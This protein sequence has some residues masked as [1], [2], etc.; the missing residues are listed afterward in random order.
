MKKIEPRSPSP[1]VG[2][3]LVALLAGACA[4]SEMSPSHDGAA[5]GG[6]PGAG[7]AG[8]AAP[9]AGASPA[10]KGGAGG[11]GGAGG[12]TGGTGGMKTSGTGGATGGGTCDV[13]CSKI[14]AAG[15]TGFTATQADCA[16]NCATTL[17]AADCGALGTTYFTCVASQGTVSCDASGNPTAAGCAASEQPYTMC[18]VCRPASGDAACDAC[19]KMSCCS[20]YAAFVTAPDIA[21]FDTCYQ[22]CTTQACVDACVKQFPMAGAAYNA[23]ASCAGS[24]CRDV[25]GM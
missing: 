17:A 25:C 5:S 1:C 7:G 9:D 23:A 6:A 2:A 21:G 14:I 4:S 16:S 22:P 19:A 20:Q 18:L 12:G 10:G 11:A 8:G 24:V 13:S 15:C 3:L